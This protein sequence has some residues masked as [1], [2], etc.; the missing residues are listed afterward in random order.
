ML[1]EQAPSCVPTFKFV[2]F[3]HFACDDAKL[4]IA[5][6]FVSKS[7]GD[8]LVDGVAFGQGQREDL[9]VLGHFPFQPLACGGKANGGKPAKGSD[10]SKGGAG[11]NAEPSQGGGK[12]P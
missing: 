11:N 7:L 12:G 5:D 1:R 10:A 2:I 9:F 3:L 8:Q 6:L 4:N